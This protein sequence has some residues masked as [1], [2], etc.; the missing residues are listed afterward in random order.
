MMWMQREGNKKKTENIGGIGRH[1]IR[2]LLGG[3]RVGG[4]D[5]PAKTG[6]AVKKVKTP[7]G[8]GEGEM[9]VERT[10]RSAA[11]NSPSTRE[12]W[13]GGSSLNRKTKGRTRWGKVKGGTLNQ[14]SISQHI[15]KCL[16]GGANVVG[17]RADIRKR[18]E[19]GGSE[20][21]RGLSGSN[22]G[23]NQNPTRERRVAGKH[24]KNQWGGRGKR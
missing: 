15:S 18:I 3:G 22:S 16:G 5:H 24:K 4:S 17:R 20:T 7:N 1:R 6:R 8:K 2:Y 21:G 9:V 12:G 14:A 13:R 11:C 19:R 10:F 23:E